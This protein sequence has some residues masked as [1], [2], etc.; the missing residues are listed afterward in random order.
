MYNVRPNLIIGFH[1]CDTD[2][3]NSLL[4]NPNK[5][6]KSEKPYDWLGHGVYFWENNY[7][8]ALRWAKEKAKR[9]EI[10]KPTVIGAVIQ[11]GFCCDLL[12][13]RFITMLKEY[14][15]LMVEYYKTLDKELPENKD[16]EQDSYKDKIFRELDCTTIEF[17]H[18]EILNTIVKEKKENGFC[19]YKM[20]DSV[21]GVFTEGGP[22]FPGAGIFDK[23]HIQIC[24]RNSNCIKGFFLP[25]KEIDFSPENQYK[26]LIT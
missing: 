15:S 26:S 17:M 22:V 20:F 18:Q 24:I 25:R 19:E 1:G 16:I 10:K 3:C 12:D 14:Y 7:E 13:S 9:K 23:S 2:T 6:K 4:N 5:I 21:R 8:R 11:L